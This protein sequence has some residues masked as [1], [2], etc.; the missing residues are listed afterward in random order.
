MGSGIERSW[1]RSHGNRKTLELL[2]A[3]TALYQQ[4]ITTKEPD[5][6][7]HYIYSIVS[8]IFSFADS[9]S[10]SYLLHVDWNTPL[11]RRP[12]AGTDRGDLPVR[13]FSNLQVRR[14]R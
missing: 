2:V 3:A 7:A 8:I 14:H 6:S 5:L 1:E 10:S 4:L 11:R 9:A 12:A 13:P